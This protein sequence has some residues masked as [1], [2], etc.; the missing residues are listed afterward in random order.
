MDRELLQ[1]ELNKIIETSNN[2]ITVTDQDGIILRSNPN[3]WSI[4]GIEPNQYI[5][6]SVYQ[7]QKEGI[8]TPSIHARVLEDKKPVQILQ[9]T[10]TGRTVMATGFPVFDHNGKIIRAISYSQDQTEIFNLQ[11]QYKGLEKKLV[12]YQT[13]V[14]ELR[15]KES[16]YHGILY[17]SPSIEQIVKTIYRV[18]KTDA[19]VLLLGPSGVGK[20]T[21]A[22]MLHAQSNRKNEPFIEVNC[23]TI[24]ETLFESEMFGYDPGSFTGA[25][26]HGKQG[27]IEQAEQGTLFLDEIGELPL[28]MQS[29]LLRVLQEKKVMRIGGKKERQVNFRLITATNKNIEEMVEKGEFR[30]DLFYRINII[31]LQIPPLKERKEDLPILINHYVQNI[32]EKYQVAKKFHASTYD[33]LTQY[34]WPGNVRELENILERVIL[35]ADEETIFPEHLP[36]NLR[37][38]SLPLKDWALSEA[39][40]VETGEHHDWKTAIEKTET[41]LL[42]RAVEYCKTTYEMAEYLGISQPSV[43]RKLKQYAINR[44]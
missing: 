44:K 34:N 37:G 14:E 29:K 43:V 42:R 16:D 2:N 20:S 33:V 15:G 18:S 23:S 27:L 3:H 21:F 4:Y 30:L 7:L 8:L 10:K 26:K 19:S 5:G 39:E 9:K 41:H 35:T 11:E 6:K 28:T 32:N 40:N 1:T 36:A 13:E 25:S 38:S 31:P 22:R 12:S 17:R 24:P